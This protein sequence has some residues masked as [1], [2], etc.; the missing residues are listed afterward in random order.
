VVGWT[1]IGDHAS[2]DV[3]GRR[4]VQ[5]HLAGEVDLLNVDAVESHLAERVNG[6]SRRV[7]VDLSRVTFMGVRGLGLLVRLQSRADV[8]GWEL[9]LRHPN[10]HV[11]RLLEA[12]GM[13]E[14]F[15][16]ERPVP[17][18]AVHA[19]TP[20]ILTEA[21]DRAMLEDRADT[22]SA[23]LADPTS[24]VLTLVASPGFPRAFRDFFEVVGDE[25]GASCAVAA[26]NRSVEVVHDVTT[27]PIFVGTPSL[28]V[29]VESNAYSCISIPVLAR[30]D[31]VAGMISVHH[32]HPR[33]W[34]PERVRAL[35]DIASDAGRELE[36]LVSG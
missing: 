28:D 22:G 24:G 34:E 12:T 25:E 5:V 2:A 30:G 9:T 11:R 26:A 19:D 23:Q 35:Q 8:G 4:D 10:H 6:H 7:A 31:R 27:S 13:D 21:L 32:D 36:A 33:D 17:D 14:V 3:R 18:D 16:V 1:R 20:A 29:M 15:T